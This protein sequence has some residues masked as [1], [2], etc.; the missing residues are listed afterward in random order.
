M[1]CSRHPERI[2]RSWT[3]PDWLEDCYQ[4]IRKKCPVHWTE[5]LAILFNVPAIYGLDIE[6]NLISLQ[7]DPPPLDFRTSSITLPRVEFTI[8]LVIL[9]DRSKGTSARQERVGGSEY[10]IWTRQRKRVS[11]SFHSIRRS[12]CAAHLVALLA[13][14]SAAVVSSA[15]VQ[16]SPPRL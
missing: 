16:T 15:G 7:Y 8:S 4:K 9:Q 2:C 3:G 6:E 1:S 14:H 10:S 13:T 5:L 12:N 11:S